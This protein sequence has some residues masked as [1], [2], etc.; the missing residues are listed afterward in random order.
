MLPKDCKP[1]IV[2]DAGF[3][4]PWL[5]QVRKLGW[6]YVARV[7]GN[8]KLKLAEQDKFISVNQLYRQAKKDPKSVGKKSC[9]PKHNTMKRRPSWLAK[10]ISY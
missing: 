6:H 8:V 2:T 10:V 7:R 4:V 9:L 1:V 5:K 3:K